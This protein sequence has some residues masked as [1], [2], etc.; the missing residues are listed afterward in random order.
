MTITR[1]PYCRKV[2]YG[3]TG[4]PV[5]NEDE[6]DG[7]FAPGV[8]VRPTLIELVYSAAR[9]G[10]PASV[11]ASVAGD[12]MRFGKP[13]EPGGQVETHFKSG[14][15]GWPAWLAEEARLH[16]PDAPSA[17]LSPDTAPAPATWDD[18]VAEAFRATVDRAAR[19]VASQDECVLLRQ[20]TGLLLADLARTRQEL[21]DQ[22][23]AESADAAAGSYAGR[24]ERVEAQL[25][26]IA[27][28][29]ADHEG[30]EW[31]AHPA[32]TALRGILD[33]GE[34]A[35]AQPEPWLHVAFTS[36][37]P[38]TA[39]TSA[40][41]IADHLAAEFDG[42]SMRI[43]SN[44]VEAE[45]G[46]QIVPNGPLICELPHQTI[47]EE[48]ACERQRV[49]AAPTALRD[50]LTASLDEGFRT[51]DADK[52]ED[53]YLIEHLIDAVLGP[54]QP[55]L[56]ALAAYENAITW[57]TDCLSCAR[58]LDS[59]IRETWRAEK[60][61]GTVTRITALYEQWVKAGPPPL[62][63][64]M[65]RWWDRRLVELRAAIRPAGDN[66]TGGQL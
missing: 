21:A 37:D 48:D 8:G 13:Q 50:Q 34:H 20:H 55:R 5:L 51:F 4:A 19:G 52:T 54:L 18:V 22:A 40:L 35:I 39:N 24:A 58:T 61:E 23:E 66:P 14:P 27:D 12:W 42:V 49:T 1:I 63:A 41:A 62:G 60:A 25:A 3:I 29:I 7:T 38:T 36:P 46:R 2:R 30:D 32:T 45:D 10:K 57:H 6:M 65:A 17:A 59:S 11:S 56:A 16:A 43:T 28:L 31:A 15:A 44:A 33:S 9:D 47:T 26:A 64:S 53:A